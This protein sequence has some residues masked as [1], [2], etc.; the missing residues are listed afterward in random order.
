MNLSSF[1]WSNKFHFFLLFPKIIKNFRHFLSL[2]KLFQMWDLQTFDSISMLF[3]WNF[4]SKFLRLLGKNTPKSFKTVFSFLSIFNIS[5]TAFW[6]KLRVLKLLN[7]STG[8]FM[9]EI[10]V[11]GGIS[12]VPQIFVI[13]NYKHKF[14][15]KKCILFEYF[16]NCCKVKNHIYNFQ[17]S[18]WAFASS[19]L[20]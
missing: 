18:T 2:E 6:K 15:N 17:A 20:L 4:F 13:I 9:I 8:N 3:F 5:R 11:G 19:S 1:I 14:S 12:F 16:R 10:S 7:N